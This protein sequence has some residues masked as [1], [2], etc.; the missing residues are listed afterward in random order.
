LSLRDVEL[1]LAE[2]GVVV[3][4]ET[5]RRWCCREL[6]SADTAPRTADATVQIARAGPGLPRRSRVHPWPLLSTPA[7]PGSRCISCKQVRGIW[8][9][10][11]GDVRPIRDMI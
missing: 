11:P 9:L 6:T 1:L 5:V 7:S 3:S 4:Y 10:A 2:R 8:C